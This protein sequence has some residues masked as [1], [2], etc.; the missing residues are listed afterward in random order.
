MNGIFKQTAVF[1]NQPE[2]N[3]PC[4]DA[5][6]DEAACLTGLDKPQLY[7]VEKPKNIPIHRVADLDGVI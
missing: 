1:V 4:V 5:D 3:A 2:I 6:A 7:V